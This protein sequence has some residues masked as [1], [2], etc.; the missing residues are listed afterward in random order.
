M[1]RHQA[2]RVR[3]YPTEDQ[4]IIL[5]KTFGCCRLIYNLALEQRRDFWRKGR[6]ITYKTWAAEIGALKATFPFFSEAPYHCLQQ[7]LR[8]LEEAYSRFFSGD[9]G[10]PR[11]RRKYENDSCRFPDP[12][13]IT[14]SRGQIK[15]PK[16]GLIKAVIHHPIQGRVNSVTVSRE[17]DAFYA[18][19]L[20]SIKVKAPEPRPIREVAYDVGVGQSAVEDDGTVH[21]API[22]SLGEQKRKIRLQQALARK[23]NKASRRRK[24][25]VEQL[26]R[27]EARMACRRRDYCHRTSHLLT[28]KATHLAAED[29]KIRNITASAK[30]S[31]E[32]PGRNVRQKAG[33]N[34][35]IL[36]TAPDT[37]RRMVAYKASWRGTVFVCVDA[38]HTSQYC[39]QCG[40]HPKDDPS[41]SDLAHGRVTRDRFECPLCGFTADADVNAARNIRARGR[42]RWV[43]SLNSAEGYPG[44]ARGGLCAKQAGDPRTKDL[45]LSRPQAA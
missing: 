18:S 8:D 35:G 44:A 32:A 16:L 28:A 13:Q 10:Y 22:M 17:G 9:A 3:I 42:L 14:V 12:K 36:N 41:T 26:R 43:A 30:G 23:P 6:K 1:R 24:R 27:L 37:L 2:Y 31:V 29:L 33:L 40:N 39:S 45:G 11:P 25:A 4:K 38:R 7:A 15:L 19:V 20:V 5:S 21:Q 34:R